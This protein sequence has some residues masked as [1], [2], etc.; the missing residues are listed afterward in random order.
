M[1]Q[2]ILENEIRFSNDHFWHWF[3]ALLRGFDEEKELNLDEAIEEMT[4]LDLYS[5]EIKE[6]YMSF[7]PEYTDQAK[8]NYHLAIR[9]KLYV[10]IQFTP[11]EIRYYLNDLYIGNIGGHFE[12]WFFS[13][14]EFQRL[15]L[16]DLHFLLLLPMLAV[17]QN[18]STVVT[19]LIA[20][21]L[22]NIKSFQGH[23]DYIASCLVNGLVLQ[24]DFYL[25]ESVGVCNHQNHSIRN[26]EQCTHA[27]E[28]IQK[29]NE[30]LNT[31]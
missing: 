4:G 11:E 25:D 14:K 20:K 9:S 16:T 5:R 13:L 23:E 29:L 18:Q 24:Q 28:H 15:Q 26:I 1:S 21:R 31:I 8:R 7:L 17:E 27:V 19:A 30:L 6:W 3:I 22:S 10:D 2:H 12:A